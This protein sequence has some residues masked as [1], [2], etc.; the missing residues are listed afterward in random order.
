MLSVVS[1]I[2]LGSAPWH[3]FVANMPFAVQVLETPGVLPWI[4][5]PTVQ[6]AAMLLGSPASVARAI[7][8]TAA[9]VA[10]IGVALVWA[11]GSSLPSRVMALVG[12]AFLVTPFAFDYD[13]AML[14]L[15]AAWL[16][17][18]GARNGFR[19]GELALVVAA[20][21]APL[22]LPAIAAGTSIQLGPVL[23][24]SLLWAAWKRG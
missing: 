3:A 2:L 15:P 17:F 8:G 1:W 11:R 14:A 4:R 5:M 12:A 21:S 24:A 6:V 16:G 23:S 19:R 10:I 22:S 20:W 9:V 7:Q 13:T 18:E